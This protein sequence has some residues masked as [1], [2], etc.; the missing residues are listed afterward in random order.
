MYIYI[1]VYMY[2]CVYTQTLLLTHNLTHSLF[3]FM[4]PCLFLSFSLSLRLSLFLSPLCPAVVCSFSFYASLAHTNTPSRAHTHTHSR[5][6]RAGEMC[7]IF[8][9]LQLSGFGPAT[10]CKAQMN[11]EIRL[12]ATSNGLCDL[13]SLHLKR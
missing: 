8:H 9:R 11:M 2:S 12:S 7:D 6:K 1:Y 3:I 5:T 10:T 13:T 4:F